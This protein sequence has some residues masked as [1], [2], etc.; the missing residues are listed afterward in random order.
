M[1]KK[2]VKKQKQATLFGFFS[3]K[4]SEERVEVVEADDSTIPPVL[5]IPSTPPLLDGKLSQDTSIES[6]ADRNAL[7]RP[8]RVEKSE[9][10]PPRKRRKGVSRRVLDEEESSDESGSKEEREESRQIDVSDDVNESVGDEEDDGSVYLEEEEEEEED[11][12]VSSE[13]DE[14]RLKESDGAIVEDQIEFEGGSGGNKSWRIPASITKSDPKRRR[15]FLRHLSQH[16]TSSDSFDPTTG[17]S[18][19]S[20]SSAPCEKSNLIG[21]SFKN[22][23]LSALTDLE[24]QVY[25]IKMRH[26]DVILF[27]ECG[28]RYRFFGQ[29][30]VIASEKLHIFH[31]LDHS[32]QTASVPTN[33][34]HVHLRRLVE[35]GH[36]C[37]VVKQTETAALKRKKQRDTGASSGRFQRAL[38]G[39]FSRGTLM[40][41]DP[42]YIGCID[43]WLPAG[44][45]AMRPILCTIFINLGLGK[46]VWDVF[47]DDVE[48]TGL[49]MRWARFSPVEVVASRFVGP[50]SSKVIPHDIL[51]K[52]IVS[53]KD[54]KKDQEEIKLARNLESESQKLQRNFTR[55]KK[56]LSDFDVGTAA[57]DALMHEHFDRPQCLNLDRKAVRH[58]DVH[59]ERG[60]LLWFLD[61][62]KTPQKKALFL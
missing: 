8:R 60:G 14:D 3:K 56:Y 43:E 20:S 38:S 49:R 40:D 26:P 55:L 2:T 30:A 17:L 46:L 61:Q 5:P 62:T 9:A 18:K 13:D 16:P 54:E 41:A 4:P 44:D 10:E 24:R 29:D 7:M 59:A 52:S 39:I 33:R 19:A 22:V 45:D 21:C 31:R 23:K 28:Y 15:L 53:L 27:V 11:K 6:V 34:L 32:F 48:R 36:K 25:E 47:E 58:L 42:V 51:Q 35:F 50:K 37:G 12:S 1:F 57:F